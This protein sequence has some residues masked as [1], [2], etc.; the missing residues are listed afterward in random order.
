MLNS[1]S[2]FAVQR[3][4]VSRHQTSMTDSVLAAIGA[5]LAWLGWEVL[6]EAAAGRI[7]NLLRPV[8][9]PIW[10]AFVVARWPWPLLIALPL[11]VAGMLE[12]YSLLSSATWR[13]DAGLELFFGGAGLSLLTLIVWSESRRNAAMTR[14]PAS[15]SI[16]VRGTLRE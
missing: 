12:G 14:G 11:G 13:A 2:A 15:G 3:Q 10:H 7:A 6:H 1:V 9:R 4:I 16:G 8:T 5:I